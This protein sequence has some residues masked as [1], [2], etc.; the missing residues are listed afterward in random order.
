MGIKEMFGECATYYCCAYTQMLSV[1]T[2]LYSIQI[3]I[4][5]FVPF[6]YKLSTTRLP[7]ED[8]TVEI[9]TFSS[10]K[11]L[12]VAQTM[13]SLPKGNKK[14]PSFIKTHP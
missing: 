4:I 2:I 3:N 10:I 9:Q 12:I 7:V 6:T 14:Q 11:I 8:L 5:L 1:Y 13:I